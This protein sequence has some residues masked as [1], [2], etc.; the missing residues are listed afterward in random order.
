MCQSFAVILLCYTYLDCDSS[1]TRR[2]SGIDR[3]HVRSS[4]HV[5]VNADHCIV[6][7]VYNLF[8]CTEAIVSN[9]PVACCCI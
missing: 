6:C 3:C 7:V 4:K 1:G 2:Q 5:C 8:N 9:V